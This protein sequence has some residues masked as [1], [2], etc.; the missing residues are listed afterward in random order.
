MKPSLYLYLLFNYGRKAPR[1]LNAVRKAQKREATK[2][3]RKRR[4]EAA[5]KWQQSAD[6]IALAV[7]SARAPILNFEAREQKKVIFRDRGCGFSCSQS[8]LPES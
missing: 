7:F 4:V 2:I 8:S 3:A 5:L 6:I 1:L